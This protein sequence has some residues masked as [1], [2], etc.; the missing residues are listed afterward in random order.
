M[1]DDLFML[2]FLFLVDNA[3]PDSHCMA[4]T[5]S[6]HRLVLSKVGASSR[7]RH[8]ASADVSH[9]DL[10]PPDL[11]WLEKPGRKAV[12]RGTLT[13]IFHR[14]RWDWRKSQR[15][16]LSHLAGNST[17]ELKEVLVEAKGGKVEIQRW[18]ERELVER[19]LDVGLV[20][21]V[22]TV[23][24]RAKI[25]ADFSCTGYTELGRLSRSSQLHNTD[26]SDSVARAP[27]ARA[28]TLMVD[29]TYPLALPVKLLAIKCSPSTLGSSE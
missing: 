20:K 9:P 1:A 2:C 26:I 27:P 4:R 5:C 10:A 22:S 8:G 7:F 15:H 23:Q 14:D 16:R 21:D 18:S 29:P 19:Y 25:S 13:G 11:S 6:A 24:P 17:D 3:W 12:W 28:V